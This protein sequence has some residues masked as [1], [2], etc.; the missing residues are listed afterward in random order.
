MSTVLLEEQLK[1]PS[2]N[3]NFSG[4]FGYTDA[5]YTE[6][7]EETGVT[8]GQRIV[9]TPR[10]T[11]SLLGQY[12]FPVADGYQGYIQGNYQWTDDIYDPDAGRGIPKRDAF[13]TLGLRF[14][15]QHENWEV[16]VFADNLTDERG[17]LFK[18]INQAAGVDPFI[19][20]TVGV[21][22]PRT[23]GITLRWNGGD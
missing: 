10:M 14:G 11:A 9:N 16:V 1:D 6:D 7:S 8:A 22:R 12:L 5:T 19:A 13:G 20:D 4:S 3:L 21:I 23:Y 17:M 15:V 18:Y 2:E